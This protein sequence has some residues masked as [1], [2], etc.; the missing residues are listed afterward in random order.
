MKRRT[1]KQFFSIIFVPDQEQD[2]KSISMSYATGRIILVLMAVLIVHFVVG[3]VSY[4]RVFQLEKAARILRNE[5]TD[6]KARNKKI[7]EIF[8][9]FN[10]VQ[11]N[12]EKIRRA[13][14][15]TLGLRDD[16]ANDLESI[17]QQ[18]IGQITETSERQQVASTPVNIEQ[19]QNSRYF[20]MEKK[21][22]YFDP[23]YLPTR[24]P[25]EGFLTTRFQKGGWFGGRSHYGI[26]IAAK[27]G[28]VI[29]ASGS[30]IVVLAD[31]TP[32]YGNVIVV[33]H[34]NGFFTYYAHAM[35]L[36]VAQ[37]DRIRKGQQIAL[38]GSSGSSSAPHLHF[39]IWKDGEPV[40]PEKFIYALQRD[41][42]ETDS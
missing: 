18:T 40:D 36:L 37:G 2:P 35:R 7:E 13:F 27:K 21:G 1:R 23:E 39:E 15:V 14:G 31:W 17:P 25:A 41:E 5:N 20:L 34:G 42:N 6:L 24:L 22:G 28:S 11:I 9:L 8:R 38:L 3:G 12:H 29:L 19:I 32:D 10:E 33:S 26:D 16:E 30:G 4:Y